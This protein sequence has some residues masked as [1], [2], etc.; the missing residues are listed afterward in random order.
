MNSRALRSL[1]VAVLLLTSATLAIIPVAGPTRAGSG[2]ATLAI[3]PSSG[4]QGTVVTLSGTGYSANTVEGYCFASGTAHSNL[5]LDAGSTPS[6]SHPD[7][8]FTTDAS[9]NIPS[10][11]TDTVPSSSFGNVFIIVCANS[12][13]ATGTPITSAAYGTTGCITFNNPNQKINK[14]ED[15]KVTTTINCATTDG[16]TYQWYSSTDASCSS[17]TSLGSSYTSSTLDYTPAAAGTYYFCL[18]VTD[19]VT[20]DTATA[21]VTITVNPALVAP[22]IA[23][24]P[25]SI[26]QGQSSSLSMT[27][28]FSGGASPYTCQWLQEA[29]G[30][31]SYSNLG[32]SFSCSAGVTTYT[33]STGTLTTSGTWSFE[34]QVSDGSNSPT[35][36]GFST[37]A[38]VAVTAVA[39]NAGAISPSTPTIDSGQS[40]SLAANPYGGTS[41]YTYQWYSGS[42][43]S[44]TVLGTASSLSVSSAGTYFVYVTDSATPT[45]A[46]ACSSGDAVAVDSAPVAGSVTPSTPVIDQGQSVLLTAPAPTGGTGT[47]TYQWYT[48]SSPGTCTTGDAPISG[49]T[50]A[51][52]AVPTSTTSGIYYYCYIITDTGV[53]S[54][55]TPAPTSGSG[56]D[57]VTVNTPLSAPAISQASPAFD[58]GGSTSLTVTSAFS[59]GTSSYTCQWLQEAPGASSYSNLGSSF[60]CSAGVTTYTQSTGTLTTSGVYSFEL[61]VTDSASTPVT[62]TSTPTTVT[63]NPLPSSVSL[64]S[65]AADPVGPTTSDSVSVS[66]SGGTGTFTVTLYYSTSSSSCSSAD[67]QAGQ[68]TGASSSPQTLSFTSPGSANTYYYCAKVTDANSN[69]AAS[70]TS[71]S[72]LTVNNVLS[73]GAISPSPVTIDSSQSVTLTANPTGGNPGYTY[74]WYSGSGCSGSVLGTSQTFSP[75]PSSTTTYYVLVTDSTSA[76][77]CSSGDAVT[78]DSSP[79]AGAITAPGSTIDSGQSLLL[80]SHPSGGTGTFAYQWYSASSPGTCSTSDASISGATSSTYTVPTSTSAGTYYYCYIVTDAGVTSGSSPTPT[81][82]SS[83]F[84]VTVDAILA[85]GAVTP[86]SPIIDSG[87]SVT[88]TAHPSGGTGSYTYQWYS[89]SSSTCSSDITTLGTASTQAVS[90]TSNIYYCYSVTDSSTNP[91]TSTS[92]ANLVTVDSALTAGAITPTSPTINSGVSV[93]L[94][95]HPSGGTGSYAYQWY[96]GSSAACSSDSA[97][98]GQTSSTYAPSPTSNTYYCYSVTDT[99]TNTPT[100][101]S[102]TDL[103]TV[104]VPLAAGTISPSSPTIDNGQS[105]TLAVNPSGGTSP[106]T[107]QWYTSSDCSTSPISGATASTLA[108]SPGSSTTYYVKVTDS[109]STTS[110]SSGDAVTVDS[111]LS[112]GAMTPNGP[113]IDSGQS[114]TLTANPSGGTGSYTYKWYSGSSTSC[115]SDT[116]TLGTAST[117]VVSPTTNTYYCYSVSDTSTNPPTVSSATGVVTVD[118]A[119]SAGAITPASPTISSGSIVTLTAHPSGGTGLYTYQ[120]YS[121][122][123]STCSSDTAVSGQ[124]SSTYA[125]SPTSNTYYCY[126][127]SDTSTNAP[128]VSSAT[129]LASVTSGLVAGSIAPSSPTID[130]GQSLT[131]TANPSGGTTPY[132]YQWYTS[133]DCS[134]SPVSG[135]TSSTYAASPTS[136]TTYYVKVTDANSNTACSAGDPV[137]VDTALSAGAITPGAPTIDSGQSITLTAHP[138]GGSGSYSYH[139]YSGPSSSCSSDATAL[140][141][142]STQT[143]SPASNTYY[144]YSLSDT[145]TNPPTV[146]SATDLVTVDSALSAGAVTPSSPTVDNGQSV[147]LTAHPSGGTGAYTYQ[148]YSGSSSTCSSDT[149]TLGTS[150]AQVVSPTSNTYYCYSISDTSTNPPTT[151]SATDQVAVDTALSA[152]AITPASPTIDSGQSLTLTAHPSGGTGSYTYQWYSGSSAACTSDTT[153][154]GTSS[155][156]LVSPTSNTYYCYEVTDASTNPPAVSSPTDLVTVNAAISGVTATP[157]PAVLDSGQSGTLQVSWTGGTADFTI[158]IYSGS[159]STSC[160]LDITQVGSAHANIGTSPLTGV[161]VSPASTTYYCATVVD[162]VTGAVST[163]SPV[164]VTVNPALSAG[165]ITPPSPTISSGSSVLLTAN[166]NGGTTAYAYQWFTGAGCTSPISGAISST[167]DASPSSTTAYYYQV[168]DSASTPESACSAGDTVTVNSPAPLPSLHAGPLSPSTATIQ[169]GSDVTFRVTPTGGTSPYTYYWSIPSGVTVVSG[170]DS[171]ADTCTVTS[172]APGSYSVSVRVTDSANDVSTSS[173]ATLKVGPAPLSVLVSAPVSA[174]LGSPVTFT[175]TASGGTSPY[176]YS[177]NLP[178]GMSVASGCGP[179]DQS[180]TV[181]A[182]APGSYSVGLTVTDADGN[183]ATSSSSVTYGST[184]SPGGIEPPSPSID[185]GQPI[186]LTIT[187]SGGVGPYSYEWFTGADCSGQVSGT[188]SSFTVSPSTTTTYWVQVTDATGT[189]SC[190]G[191]DAV[192]VNGELIAGPITPSAPTI[193]AGQSIRLSASPSGGTAPYSYQWYAGA[194]C[195]SPVSGATAASFSPSPST[196]TVYSYK[197]TDSAHTPESACSP[198]DTVAVGSTTVITITPT[199]GPPGT[200]IFLSGSNFSPG[201]NYYYCFEPGVTLST[202]SPCPTTYEFTSTSSGAVPPLTVLTAFGQNGLVVVSDASTGQIVAYAVFILTTAPA[203]GPAIAITPTSGLTGTPV[204]VDGTGFTPGATVNIVI[205]R[206]TVAAATVGPNGTFSA[207]FSVP[208]SPPGAETVTATG[209]DVATRPG[210][211]A[212]TTFIVTNVG[213]YHS[214]VFPVTSTNGT[215]VVDETATTGISVSIPGLGNAPGTTLRI[216]LANLTLPSYGV[217]A[218]TFTGAI[219]YFDVFVVGNGTIPTGL[220]AH[221]CITNSIVGAGTGMQY[222]NGS[223]WVNP[224]DITTAGFTICGTVP[225]ARLG[226]TNFAIGNLQSVP[227]RVGIASQIS[228]IWFF[229]IP[230]LVGSLVFFFAWFFLIAG[231]RR[232]KEE[233]EL[234]TKLGKYDSQQRCLPSAQALPVLARNCHG[235]GFSALFDISSLLQT[236]I[237]RP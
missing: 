39:L 11:I 18:I 184:L 160:A 111:T 180:C 55:S 209:S 220:N 147:T 232:R 32:S 92:A 120:W 114:V 37:P 113:T 13:C 58:V 141:T 103:V 104:N 36:Q 89:G 56:T 192:T 4:G 42:G 229:I 100:V 69:S 61:K 43:C 22:T 73:A 182:R 197:V 7:G 105:V 125:P 225:I 174:T 78:V 200:L 132:S 154:L 45:H 83:T 15:F 99:S 47:F 41:P 94:T 151:S 49:A 53:T 128:T 50:S 16:F 227:T 88:L 207:T 206:G 9:G 165:A 169:A 23:A 215:A 164:A 112:A 233:E 170:C 145:S 195:A 84:T 102:A 54:G 110:C 179:S 101:N 12:T 72:S 173:P 150:S 25:S 130:S 167:Y 138:T 193:S 38:T 172:A 226:G 30:A 124:T 237:L 24:T 153:P 109:T 236:S 157:S 183:T 117:Q 81:A 139:W 162:S 212:T 199:S 17:L 40:I 178:G 190:V 213:N 46:T 115:A 148:W 140:G 2:T 142:G 8:T 34:L 137:T 33:Q 126:S 62:T 48:A 166:P 59:G 221:V 136:T 86:T 149:A 211:V 231:K 79:S 188:S 93:T 204:T 191:G 127:I 52:Y 222:W 95:A 85:A 31:S 186:T 65:F 74:Q 135:A 6:S 66:W 118:S 91:P 60:S 119:L 21:E 129:D 217:T 181:I 20:T 133:A 234:Q 196:S 97:V 5:C 219:R 51:S 175:A 98:S 96:S 57:Q 216:E 187:P 208:S 189:K 67:T 171:T 35:P 75:F 146:S 27:S 210:D 224:S 26:D 134:T 163:S 123:S 158:T 70:P 44:G 121:G 106:Y 235:S 194:G 198:V 152:G 205:S 90:P 68:V 143:V 230:M 202:M 71:G 156:Q 122:S 168:T 131:L 177:W 155:I 159:S 185:G 161:S 176:T 201:G 10:G 28:G 116:A 77:S 228:W 63:A 87:Q 3:N 203:G 1:L 144:C 76:T 14:G 19:T 64:G 214:D 108:A 82:S 223:T 218:E 80:T 29:P 107:Y